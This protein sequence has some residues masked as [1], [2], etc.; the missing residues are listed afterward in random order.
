[1]Q[2]HKSYMTRQGN[3][4]IVY[5]WSEDHG[6]YQASNERTYHQAQADVGTA[7]CTD[8]HCNKWTHNH[9]TGD[10][11]ANGKPFLG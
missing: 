7:N 11:F 8:Q 10:A 1:M 6:C 9:H 2:R 3:G 5:H 4:W